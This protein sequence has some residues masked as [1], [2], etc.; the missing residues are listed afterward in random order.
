MVKKIRLSA[1]DRPILTGINADDFD[2]VHDGD[3]IDYQVIS[4]KL[5]K[6]KNFD[7][8]VSLRKSVL[9]LIDDHYPEI[10]GNNKIFHYVP[11]SENIISVPK[12]QDLVPRK[13]DT[14]NFSR[15]EIFEN[16]QRHEVLKEI[17]KFIPANTFLNFENI[18]HLVTDELITN[19]CLSQ[20]CTIPPVRLKYAETEESV[21][22]Q[23][24]DNA[25]T[26]TP[27]TIFNYFSKGLDNLFCENKKRGAG[28][29]LIFIYYHT[30]SLIIDID[31]GRYTKFYV[32]LKKSK[33]DKIYYQ[34]PKNFH[35]FYK[36]EKKMADREF[37]VNIETQ[38]DTKIYNFSGAINE[39]FTF[40]GLLEGSAS[41]YVFNLERVSLLNS[42]GI[43][44][45]IKFIGQLPK[46]AELEYHNCPT[47]VVLQM[48]MVK[49]F[50]SENAKVISFYAPYYDEEADEEVK[51]LLK[52]DQIIDGKAPEMKNDNGDELEFD[53]IEATYFK[54]L[55]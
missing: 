38:G 40:G 44:E 41:K 1:K 17:K 34:T 13:K 10:I 19:A 26:L 14:T 53:G 21:W 37:D 8:F 23:V 30:T 54:F 31:P 49:G 18:I 42:C 4:S 20:K 28:L 24:K 3:P 33:R 6:V 46:E 27:E 43:R 22:L 48:N 29:G 2:F 51:V 35:L 5:D 12:I 39:D 32:E 7:D 50:L 16:S 9:S 11:L 52:T 47:V 55:K 45:W 25:G 36:K 15:Y